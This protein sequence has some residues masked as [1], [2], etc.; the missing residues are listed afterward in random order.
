[1]SNAYDEKQEIV[2]EEMVDI[3]KVWQD[4]AEKGCEQLMPNLEKLA[5]SWKKN[6]DFAS[7]KS[8][9]NPLL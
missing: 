1:M 8:G 6:H 2:N 7:E 5:Q 4:R 3:R 9:V